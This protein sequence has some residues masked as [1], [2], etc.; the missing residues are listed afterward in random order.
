MEEELPTCP[1][2]GSQDVRKVSEIFLTATSRGRRFDRSPATGGVSPEQGD[3]A[4]GTMSEMQRRRMTSLL[5]HPRK[6]RRISYALL[7]A[8]LGVGITVS[9]CTLCVFLSG[10]QPFELAVTY[11]LVM[12]SLL[13]LAAYVYLT[14]RDRI[15]YRAS[16]PRWQRAMEMWHELV[17]CPQCDSVCHPGTSRCV[18][19]ANMKD[20]LE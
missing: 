13:L 18:P 2:C 16:L 15:D 9:P 8:T 7:A 1:H 3:A 11:V 20:L 5:A 6:P 10:K 4:R 17:Y 14:R 19:V 12:A